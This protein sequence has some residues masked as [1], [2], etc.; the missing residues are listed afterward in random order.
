MEYKNSFVSLSDDIN[1]VELDG[2]T[3]VI[4]SSTKN[5]SRIICGHSLITTDGYRISDYG[6]VNDEDIQPGD[7]Y[8]YDSSLKA[9]I[10]AFDENG[11]VNLQISIQLFSTESEDVVII[12]PINKNG[13]LYKN[14]IDNLMG[15]T[16]SAKIAV[17]NSVNSKE[18]TFYY[19]IFFESTRSIADHEIFVYVELMGNNGSVISESNPSQNVDCFGKVFYSSSFYG[20]KNKKAQE[21]KV[22]FK[23]RTFRKL[24]MPTETVN[25]SLNYTA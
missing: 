7:V 18:T 4:N 24:E 16:S 15:D 20:V 8:T 25:V 14:Q 3:S 6:G 17:W 23:I 11:K 5:V 19:S 10:W 21:A 13:G 2:F 9:P 22:K 12:D 1:E